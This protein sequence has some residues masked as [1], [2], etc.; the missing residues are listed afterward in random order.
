MFDTP[1]MTEFTV[2]EQDSAAAQDL[3]TYNA[4]DVDSTDAHQGVKFVLTDSDDARH[5]VM[6][7]QSSDAGEHE[8]VLSVKAGANLDVDAAG[9]KS[10]YELLL[11]VCDKLNACSEKIDITVTITPQND[12]APMFRAS[13][14]PNQ[15]VAENAARGT[16]LGG[17]GA[18]MATDADGDTINLLAGRPR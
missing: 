17:V 1:Y 14:L 12:N 18:Y 4:T 3:A 13:A 9:T 10:E 6:T 16:A 15:P 5:F 2:N 8:G 11:A 7:N